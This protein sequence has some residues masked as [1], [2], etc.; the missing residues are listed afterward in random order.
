M[1]WLFDV[2]D[3][4]DIV[5]HVPLVHLEE[6]LSPDATPALTDDDDDAFGWRRG[7]R[8]ETIRFCAFAECLNRV[9]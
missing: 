6:F 1:K 7:E 9:G 3:E 4:E 2:Y 5:G 8:G